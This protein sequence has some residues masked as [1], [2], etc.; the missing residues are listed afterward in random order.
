MSR[1]TSNT[2]ISAAET[3]SL[4]V[5]AIIATPIILK[6]LGTIGYGC[7]VFLSMFSMT[8]VLSFFDFGMEGAVMTSVARARAA[9]AAAR[10][11]G[12][13]NTAVLF[14]GVTGLILGC[15][16][17]AGLH[18]IT[19][20]MKLDTGA[21]PS[22]QIQLAILFTAANVGIQFLTVPFTAFLQGE[23]RF[24]GI[25]TAT[26]L[27]NL[28]QYSLLIFLARSIPRLD[29]IAGTVLALSGLRFLAA[30]GL[31]Q[32]I[33][34]GEL[35]ATPI[36]ECWREL[37]STSGW[38]LGNRLVGLVYNQTQKG[39][40]SLGLPIA[41]LG[42]FDIVA[43]P[44]TFFRVLLGVIYSAVIPKAAEHSA[45]GEREE[46][47]FLLVTLTTGAAFLLL[48]VGCWLIG[49]A[50]MILQLWVGPQYAAH[51]LVLQ[52]L[53]CAGI[54]NV[55]TSIVSTMAVGMQLVRRTLRIA[56]AVTV[57]NLAASIILLP[58]MGIT[59]VAVALCL[60]EGVGLPL[61][62]ALV[63]REL[64]GSVRALGAA[65]S[66][67]GLLAITFVVVQLIVVTAFAETPLWSVVTGLGIGGVQLVTGYV[68]LPMRQ[69]TMLREAARRFFQRILPARQVA[70]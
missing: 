60:A 30:W 66:R 7:F 67:L 28:L 63:G 37:R 48:P 15:V 51:A 20:W 4:I 69:Q 11:R 14:Y 3:F 10:V 12:I 34:R 8:G 18:L 29:I 47:T 64:P 55:V 62:L 31:S 2:L 52:L 19:I 13:L 16:L 33:L 21:I 41:N 50:G 46:L 22:D 1:L 61:T 27:L 43:R 57:T 25:K 5:A 65:S 26:I 39:L 45:R 42:L 70:T 49:Q 35:S 40:I 58:T 68:L 56:V 59:G 23:Q 53:V 9:G 6:G 36:S 24:V 38:L 17:A 54:L 32:S 44:A